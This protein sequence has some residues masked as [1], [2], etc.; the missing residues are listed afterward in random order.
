[1]IEP[2][3]RIRLVSLQ[4]AFALEACP[5]MTWGDV[6]VANKR[7]GWTYEAYSDEIG[8]ARVKGDRLDAGELRAAWA[9]AQQMGASMPPLETP[10]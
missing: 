8:L 2:E 6:R 7:S 4:I 5:W 1:M 9:L 3:R 10:G